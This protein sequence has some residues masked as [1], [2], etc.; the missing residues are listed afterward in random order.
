MEKVGIDDFIL[1]CWGVDDTG[2]KFT[3]VS[4]LFWEITA[5]SDSLGTFRAT[6]WN[7]FDV[8]E[9][10]DKLLTQIEKAKEGTND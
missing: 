7:S 8:E 5:V 9:T 6:S 3:L 10:L 1:K 4:D 2:W